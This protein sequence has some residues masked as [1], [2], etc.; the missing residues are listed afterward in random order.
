MPDTRSSTDATMLLNIQQNQERILNQLQQLNDNFITLNNKVGVIEEEQKLLRT[1]HDDLKAV[2]TEMK[3]EM[4]EK[5]KMHKE[6][7]IKQAK[8]S[9]NR[10]V[11]AEYHSKKYNSILY[12]WPE[13]KA[14]ENP[15]DSRKE[16]NN[17]LKNV[18]NID[19]PDEI[20]IANCHRLGSSTVIDD[21]GVPKSVKNRPLIFRALFWKD[22][23]TIIEKSQKLLKKYNLDN[24]TKYGVSQQ[25]PKR[26]QDDKVSLLDDFKEGRRKKLKTK[27]KIDHNSATYFLTVDGKEFLPERCT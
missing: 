19:D 11:M 1:E 17:F 27:W 3:A 2:V 26:M 9:E 10:A 12:N 21:N 15:D 24:G 13:T 6:N 23:E 14:W 16:L 22:R 18:L 20:M 8:T 25:L 4:N 5:L 7:Q